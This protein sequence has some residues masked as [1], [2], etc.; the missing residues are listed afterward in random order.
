M[1]NHPINHICVLRTQACNT[2]SN[3]E[4]ISCAFLNRKMHMASSVPFYYRV[5]YA[6][7]RFHVRFPEC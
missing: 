2:C 7:P 6:D 3:R 4:R 1:R 5:E